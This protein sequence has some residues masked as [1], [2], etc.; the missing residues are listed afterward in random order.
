[1]TSPFALPPGPPPVTFAPWSIGSYARKMR[2][3]AAAIVGERLVNVLDINEFVLNR[4]S[5]LNN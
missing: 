5:E 1:M 3:G 4:M 2:A